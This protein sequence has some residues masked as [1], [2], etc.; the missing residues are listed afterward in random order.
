MSVYRKCTSVVVPKG[1]HRVDREQKW[2]NLRVEPELHEQI[3][4]AAKQDRRHMTQWVMT[5]IDRGLAGD[6][7]QH[8]EN[9]RQQTDN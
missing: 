7:K 5:Q 4:E 6:Q 9:T 1:A 8:M 2:I 3:R